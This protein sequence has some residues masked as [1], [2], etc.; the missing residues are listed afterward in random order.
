VRD[1]LVDGVVLVRSGRLTR[2]AEPARVA[3]H[4]AIARKMRG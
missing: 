1:V 4:D 3:L 2:D